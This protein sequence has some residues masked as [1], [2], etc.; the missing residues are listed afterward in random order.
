V[1]GGLD[2][3][4]T[5]RAVQWTKLQQSANMG[6]E[7]VVLAEEVD[8]L[9]GEQIMITTSSYDGEETEIRR[10]VSVESNNV[11]LDSPLDHNH[12]GKFENL[13]SKHSTAC[14]KPIIFAKS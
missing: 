3:H 9:P 2:L 7:S 10:I 6:A 12:L 11:I 5:P 1:F 8:W 14:T 4:G 13:T